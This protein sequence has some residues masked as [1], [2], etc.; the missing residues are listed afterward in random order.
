MGKK[1]KIL[2]ISMVLMVIGFILVKNF[3]YQPHRTIS[4]EKVFKSFT[5]DNFIKAFEKDT[6]FLKTY[7]NQTISIYAKKIEL[8]FENKIGLINNKIA[9]RFE[10]FETLKNQSLKNVTI[11]GRLVGYDELLEEFQMDQCVIIENQ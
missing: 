8:D 10:D 9:T 6:L 5:A 1:G 11:K 4:E 3:L 2:I 7:T